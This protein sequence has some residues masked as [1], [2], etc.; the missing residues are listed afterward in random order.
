METL[1]RLQDWYREQCDGRWERRFGVKIDTLDNPGWS[2]TIDL[3]GTVLD[4]KEFIPTA[5]G[6]DE[7]DSHPDD[8]DWLICRVEDSQFRAYGGPAKLDEMARVFLAWADDEA[9]EEDEDEDA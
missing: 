3:S 9:P 7:D 4:D 2:L 8:D 5:Y 1:A 6:I